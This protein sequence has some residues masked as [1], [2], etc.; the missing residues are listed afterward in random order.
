VAKLRDTCPQI[1]ITSDVIVG[2]PGE[3]DGDFEQT[4][5][6]VK[7]VEY[8]GL[9]AFQYSDRPYAPAASLPDKI[10]EPV[11]SKRL[12]ILLDLQ[13]HYTKQKNQALVGS[14]QLILTDGLS[15]KQVS[16]S[17]DTSGQTLQWTGRTF[18]NKIVNFSL[19][20]LPIYKESLTGRLIDVRIDKALSHSLFGQAINLKPSAGGLK[21]VE[22]YAA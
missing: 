22:N 17:T 13:Q 12:Q 9:F 16:D 20:E 8:D 6:L 2:F 18:T 19:D 4:L 5:E 3:T 14:I 10:T 11:K 7:T 21:G 1:A 15:K